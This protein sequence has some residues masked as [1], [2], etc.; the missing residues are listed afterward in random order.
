MDQDRIEAEHENGVL[1]IR[2]PKRAEL[3]PRKVKILKPV[4]I[5]AEKP[6]K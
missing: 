4:Q 5:T 6:K 1:K 3:R 2:M